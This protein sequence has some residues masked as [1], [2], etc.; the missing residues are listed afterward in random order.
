MSIPAF[1]DDGYNLIQP[2]K[3]QPNKHNGY[4]NCPI[5]WIPENIYE[6]L[7]KYDTIKM[8]PNMPIP[9]YDKI[10]P[11]FIGAVQYYE[12]KFNEYVILVM[13]EK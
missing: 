9:A 13:K 12:S 5:R 6:L 8:F 7:K 3:Y 4:F 11:R 10:S 2:S 1:V